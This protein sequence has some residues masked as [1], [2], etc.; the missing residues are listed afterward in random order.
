[1]FRFSSLRVIQ[2]VP[3]KICRNHFWRTLAAV[4]FL[5]P[6][7]ILLVP[8]RCLA[9]QPGSTASGGQAGPEG[10]GPQQRGM[11]GNG[12]IGQI[13]SVAPGEMKISTRDGATVTVHLGAQTTFRLEQQP[14]KPEDFKAGMLVFVRG[15]KAADGS[16]EAESV[17]ART[18]PPGPGGEGRPRPGGA[19]ARPMPGD[20]VAG[21]VQAIDGT[22]ITVLRQDKTTQTVEVDENTS[23]RKRRESITLADLHTGDSVIVRGETKDGAFVPKSLNVVDAEQLQRM[24]QFM[25]GG[26]AAGGAGSPG[27]ANPPAAPATQTPPSDGKPPQELL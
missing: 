4:S 16:W 10:A 24:L 21:T 25:G 3:M 14:A 15:T 12:V 20:F 13:Q 23:L 8:G 17:A 6:A 1:M 5:L 27:K 22:K 18:G 2:K 26:G 19:G 11:R 7:L 9:Q